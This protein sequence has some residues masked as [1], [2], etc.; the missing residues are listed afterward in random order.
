MAPSPSNNTSLNT[1]GGQ[2]QPTPSPLNAA[3]DQAF[4]EKIRQL[5]RYIEPLRKIIQRSGS[6]GE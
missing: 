6:G 2:S 4:Q 5:S 3:D 1:P